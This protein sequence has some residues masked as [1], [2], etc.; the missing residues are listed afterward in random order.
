MPLP[1]IYEM[2]DLK[3]LEAKLVFFLAQ[4]VLMFHQKLRGVTHVNYSG[5]NVR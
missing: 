1:T 5:K 2:K 3:D 4:K